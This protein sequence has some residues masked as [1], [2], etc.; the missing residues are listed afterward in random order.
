M[1]PIFT[2]GEA[3]SPE[4]AGVAEDAD[5]P[6]LVAALE[7]DPKVIDVQTLDGVVQ[8]GE[9][10][11]V[12]VE[13]TRRF[14]RVSVVGMLVTTNDAFY[15]LSAVP[16]PLFGE[17]SRYSPAYDAGS[18]A[19][20]EDCMYIPGPP[21]GMGGVHDPAEAEG[22]VYIHPGIHGIGD[23]DPAEHDWR[24]PVARISIERVN[25]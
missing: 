1:D 24:N 20:S 23:L 11:S 8:P 13:G 19:N 21:C 7:S 3:A 22:Y 17:I 14:D 15:A 4:L 12:I 18:E 25:N 2:L 10:K 16:A 6:P 5:N 9:T